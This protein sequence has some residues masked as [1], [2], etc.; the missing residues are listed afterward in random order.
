MCRARSGEGEGEGEAGCSGARRLFGGS[1][2]GSGDASMLPDRI[3]TDL[4]ILTK[5]MRPS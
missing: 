1:S 5:A 3:V 2:G 4:E